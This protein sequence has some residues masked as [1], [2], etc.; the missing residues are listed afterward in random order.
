MV[1]DVVLL[2]VLVPLRFQGG[3]K[4]HHGPIRSSRFARVHLPTTSESVVGDSASGN[5]S[6]NQLTSGLERSARYA[7]L[8]HT[9]SSCGPACVFVKHQLC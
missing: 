6:V 1:V 4:L 9:V 5:G 7:F 3:T 8:G 2:P